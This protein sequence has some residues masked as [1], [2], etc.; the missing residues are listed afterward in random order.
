MEPPRQRDQ[1]RPHLPLTTPVRQ[2]SGNGRQLPGYAEP[3]SQEKVGRG[4]GMERYDVIEDEGAAIRDSKGR[5]VPHPEDRA[6][7]RAHCPL[8]RG[9]CCATSGP[10]NRLF[11]L[12]E[13]AGPDLLAAHATPGRILQLS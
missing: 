13:T 8:R 3:P 6:R 1:V 5:R 10:C 9:R 12:A 4:A 11:R 7:G 2:R